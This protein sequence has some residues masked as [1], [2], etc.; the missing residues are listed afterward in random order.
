MPA[1]WYRD[2][3]GE[4]YLDLYYHRDEVEADA[5]V[6]T[7]LTHHPPPDGGLV[8]DI[9]CG[10]GRHAHTVARRGYRVIGIDLSMTLL[11]RAAADAGPSTLFVQADKRALPL[12]DEPGPADMVLNLFTSFG[13]F[14][15]DGENSRAFAQ[16]AGALRAGGL[17]VLDFFNRE[18]V[19]DALV[20]EDEQYRE[21]LHI[22]Q[23][24][25]ITDDGKRIEKRITLTYTDDS[26]ESLLESVRLYSPEELTDL[27]RDAGL[28]VTDRWGDYHGSPHAPVSPRFILFA[29]RPA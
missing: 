22:H 8:I 13:Y 6:D 25:R 1:E 27:A 16:M 19:L 3:F 4:T 17:L 7:V 2:A 21:G 9:A 10:T 12:P 29:R 14:L 24:R 5:F 20:P 28:E 15:D 26:R 23:Q 18:H 11:K